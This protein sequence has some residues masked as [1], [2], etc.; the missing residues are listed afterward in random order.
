MAWPKQSLPARS[1]K[2]IVTRE[3]GAA[4]NIFDCQLPIAYSDVRHL[5][6]V[7]L[8]DRQYQSEIGNWQ[9]AIT[10]GLLRWILNDYVVDAQRRTRR[11]LQ[12]SQRLV[13]ISL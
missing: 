7:Q 1:S 3:K 2:G 12:V 4:Y 5:L 9:S 11:P 10:S 13:V 8:I 6:S